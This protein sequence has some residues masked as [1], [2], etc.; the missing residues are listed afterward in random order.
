MA[1]PGLASP[2]PET[3]AYALSLCGPDLGQATMMCSMGPMSALTRADIHTM[4]ITAPTRA[5]LLSAMQVCYI[6]HFLPHQRNCLS[7]LATQGKRER[8]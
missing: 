5:L 2:L 7:L 8:Q 6:L 1:S 4:L 3:C